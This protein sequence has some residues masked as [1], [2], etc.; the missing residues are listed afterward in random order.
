MNY[1]DRVTKEY[2]EGLLAGCGNC[3]IFA[4]SYVGTGTYGESNPTSLTF[5][6]TPKLIFV[7]AFSAA[8]PFMFL[9]P[10][11]THTGYILSDETSSSMQTTWS[12][13]EKN[14]SWY[15]S[16]AANLQMNE[17]HTDYFYFAIG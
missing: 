2:V 4:G 11:Q 13:N 9:Y 12:E 16:V 14:V 8:V 6:F 1:E 7:K 15:H 17:S 5:P 3:K 10:G